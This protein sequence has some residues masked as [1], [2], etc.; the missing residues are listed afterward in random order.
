M[1]KDLFCLRQQIQRKEEEGEQGRAAARARERQS[2][3]SKQV[4]TPLAP[5]F[6]CSCFSVLGI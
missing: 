2:H 1:L 3:T 5:L 4:P 6:L